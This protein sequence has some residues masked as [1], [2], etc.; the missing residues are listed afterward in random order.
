MSKTLNY[1]LELPE[2]IKI[3]NVTNN[4]EA[5]MIRWEGTKF[6]WHNG[7][8]WQDFGTGGGGGS[9]SGTANTVVKYNASGTADTESQ[10]FD[11]GTNISMYNTEKFRRKSKVVLTEAATTIW[12]MN[13]GNNAELTLTNDSILQINN[14]Q[15]GDYGTL[16]IKQG[17][18]NGNTLKIS[19]T[20]NDSL[21]IGGSNILFADPY[22][23]ILCT[24][25]GTDV[26]SF[27]F[28][29][30]NYYWSIGYDYL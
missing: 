18:S 17:N 8:S 1:R 6:Q 11:D 9:I 5:G 4:P 7:S 25:G 21:F 30:T 12:D 19:K 28:D 3:G 2:G 23:E 29:G 13:S 20:P 16:V 27:Y 10:I 24:I 15:T 26:A 22:Y 14:L